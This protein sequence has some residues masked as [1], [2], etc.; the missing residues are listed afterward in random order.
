[1]EIMEEKQWDRFPVQKKLDL[2]ARFLLL[3]TAGKRA[4]AA[5]SYRD[6]FWLH[7]VC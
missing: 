3:I 7:K 2:G 5:A 4:E 6:K 1:M